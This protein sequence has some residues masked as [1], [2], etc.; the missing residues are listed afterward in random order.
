MKRCNRVVS[1]DEALKLL[2]DETRR[3]VLLR[4]LESEADS[5][6]IDELVESLAD[7]SEKSSVAI[8]LHHVHLP[9]LAE[10][11]VI[12]FE[13]ETGEVTYLGDD[14]VESCLKYLVTHE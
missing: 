4:L 5:T 9:K 11:E 7:P 1:R 8:G 14:V 13:P 12:D 3:E 2:S 6:S 10:A